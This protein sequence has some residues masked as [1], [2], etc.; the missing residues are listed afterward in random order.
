M[1]TTMQ[2]TEISQ[3]RS[4]HS[5]DS[6][7]R[8][9]ASTLIAGYQK[10]I[11]PRKGFSCAYRVLHRSESCSQYTKRT[12]LEGGLGQAFP[13]I[14]QRFQA[15]K[16][17]NQVLKARLHKT[18]LHCQAKPQED[19]SV[20]PVTSF[21]RHSSRS[22]PQPGWAMQD[23]PLDNDAIEPD[24]DAEADETQKHQ[25]ERI[26]GGSFKK[27]PI[28]TN[29]ESTETTNQNNCSDWNCDALDCASLGCDAIDCSSADWSAMDCGAADCNGLDCSGLD[30][31]SCDF[32][33]CDCSL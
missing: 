2:T 29:G 3:R 17:A 14:Q 24:S 11:S 5:I 25:R 19:G 18:K 15:C 33:S 8:R 22:Q 4:Q 13:L 12:I 32:G 16:A 10:Q 30:C 1:Q 31:G 20:L 26:G 9:M 21:Y 7:T 23:E 28:V 27:P 6:L